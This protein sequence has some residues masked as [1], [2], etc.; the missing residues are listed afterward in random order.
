MPFHVLGHFAWKRNAGLKFV[1]FYSVCEAVSPNVYRV[2]RGTKFHLSL[3]TLS[4][5]MKSYE[6]YQE[7]STTNQK[8]VT[9]WKKA[10]WGP[11]RETKSQTERSSFPSTKL[12]LYTSILRHNSCDINWSINMFVSRD[13]KL[14]KS[15]PS[16]P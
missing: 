15:I 4:K 10:T 7:S 16:V 8:I 9:C 5:Y 2:I 13:S 14:L 3:P 6:I 12:M 11:N 1:Y